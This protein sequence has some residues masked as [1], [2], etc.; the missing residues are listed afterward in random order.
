MLPC[1]TVTTGQHTV[2]PSRRGLSRQGHRRQAQGPLALGALAAGV[3]VR[4]HRRAVATPSEVGPAEATATGKAFS[5]ERQW[6]PVLPLAM[7]SGQGPEPV[8][9][10]GRDLVLWKDAGDHW[11]CTGGICPHRLAPLAHGRVN[12]KGELMCRFHGW[13]FKGA[14][15]SYYG[16]FHVFHAWYG[17][18]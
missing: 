14:C 7:L 9:L 18:V 6:Y 10:L 1:A 3:A 8:R 15:E 5:W 11:V 2:A 12:E 4:G 16:Q 17:T 13:C